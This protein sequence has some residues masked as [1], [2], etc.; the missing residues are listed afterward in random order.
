MMAAKAPSSSAC[1]GQ[2]S[3]QA[4][5]FASRWRADR[6]YHVA[7]EDIYIRAHWGEI[8]ALCTLNSLPFNSTRFRRGDHP[9]RLEVAGL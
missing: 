4:T 7:L 8:Y 5:G 1:P 9:E 2:V 3:D 6:P